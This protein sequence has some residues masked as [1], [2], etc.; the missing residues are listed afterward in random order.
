MFLTI[1]DINNKPTLINYSNIESITFPKDNTSIIDIN[2][3]SGKTV[4][5]KMPRSILVE[6][7]KSQKESPIMVQPTTEWAG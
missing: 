7:L 4:K 6:M 1:P 3:V 2:F 5:T